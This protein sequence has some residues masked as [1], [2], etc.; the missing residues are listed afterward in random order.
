MPRG[1]LTTNHDTSQANILHAVIFLLTYSHTYL[2]RSAGYGDQSPD[3]AVS[4]ALRVEYLRV[5]ITTDTCSTAVHM[6]Y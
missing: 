1:G 2:S 3:T 4:T 6:H 5:D